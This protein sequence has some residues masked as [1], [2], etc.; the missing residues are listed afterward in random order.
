MSAACRHRFEEKHR[1]HIALDEAQKLL[2]PPSLP[3]WTITKEKMN[4]S[5]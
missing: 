3:V 5:G 1:A 2:V 4:G